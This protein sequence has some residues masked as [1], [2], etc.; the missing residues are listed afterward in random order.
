MDFFIND[1]MF[2]YKPKTKFDATLSLPKSDDYI[3]SSPYQIQS[4]YRIYVINGIL[5]NIASYGDNVQPLPDIELINKAIKLINENESWLKSYSLDVMVGPAGT[6]IIE[7]HNFAS[8]GLYSATFGMEL[9]TAYIQ[10]IEYFI[11]D[12]SIKYKT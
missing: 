8:L 1:E 6:A 9:L 2:D 12:N 11:N 7:I 4:E 3:I 5:S 10:G